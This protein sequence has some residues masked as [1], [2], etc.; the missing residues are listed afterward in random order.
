MPKTITSVS[1]NYDDGT[2]AVLTQ[3]E[4]HSPFVPGGK[5]VLDAPKAVTGAELA[6]NPAAFDGDTNDPTTQWA[7]TY[8]EGS[9]VPPSP[10]KNTM[11]DLFRANP[12]F[13]RLVWTSM[14]KHPLNESA[15]SPAQKRRLGIA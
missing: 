10:P 11:A 9:P 2:S 3:G 4:L 8:W 1:V 12:D 6:A 13:A 15:L 14:Y 7:P 5:I